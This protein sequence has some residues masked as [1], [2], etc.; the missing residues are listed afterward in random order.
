M[1]RILHRDLKLGNLRFD[2]NGTLKII[3][4]GSAAPFFG[5][6]RNWFPEDHI[7]TS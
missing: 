5:D 4:F 7:C 3:D 2:K 6:E 1:N